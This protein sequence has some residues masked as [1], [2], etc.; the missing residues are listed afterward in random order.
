MKSV[1]V[2]GAST[3]IGRATVDELVA[4]GFH[5]WATVR[6]QVDADTLTAA[7]GE[8][9]TPLLVDLLDHDSVRAA[10]ERV[11]AAGPLHGLVN[12]AGVA[13]PAPLEFMPIE[14]F[15]RQLDINLVGQLLMTQVMLPALLTERGSRVTFIGSVSGRI[16]MPTIGAY[17]TSKHAVV[18]LAGSLRAELAPFGVKVCLIEPGVIATPIWQTASTAGEQ[19][20]DAINAQTSRYDGQIRRARR[21]AEN[22]TTG[23]DPRTVARAV[24]ATMTRRSPRPRRTVGRDGLLVAIA[25]RVLPFR[26]IYWLTEGTL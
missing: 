10:G 1:V 16:A 12:N 15:S 23:A 2:T 9:V 26:A 11:V 18:G 3:G 6:K 7:H 20:L 24:L 21:S 14:D 19:T 13:L 17:V 25:T 5:V 8:S 22:G 4:A